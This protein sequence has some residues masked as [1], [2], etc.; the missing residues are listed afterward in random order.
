MASCS[1]PVASMA[2]TSKKH[3]AVLGE[4]ELECLLQSDSDQSLLDSDSDSENELE[5]RAVLDTMR[6]EESNEDDSGTQAF[7]WENMQNYKGQ[8][9]N[10][11]GSVGPQGPANGVMEIVGI[12]NC[13]SAKN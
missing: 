12:F 4:E 3:S 10:F 2:S 5:D 7:I 9:E 13:F 11:M 8:K 6:N 1:L